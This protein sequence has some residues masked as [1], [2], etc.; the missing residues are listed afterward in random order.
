[1]Q[2]P[3]TSVGMPGHSGRQI[4]FVLPSP[5]S[6]VSIL[7]SGNNSCADE[8]DSPVEQCQGLGSPLS[9]L[10]PTLGMHSG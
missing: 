1:M 6:S 2:F 10:F 9:L 5:G 7:L 3:G 8:V 4:V